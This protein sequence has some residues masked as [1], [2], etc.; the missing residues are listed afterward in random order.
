MLALF[1]LT[2]TKI[3]ASAS[4]KKIAAAQNTA[5]EG[6]F[7][8]E[9]TAVAYDD[10]KGTFTVKIKGRK[11]GKVFDKTLNISG[12]THPYAKQIWQ[13]VKTDGKGKVKLDVAIENNLS[14]DKF[15][16]KTNAGD[17][18]SIKNFFVDAL[19][20][21]LH[22]TS[23]S[24]VSITLGETD[25]YILKAQFEKQGDKIKITPEYIVKYNIKNTDGSETVEQDKS[26]S[27]FIRVKDDLIQNYFNAN[28]VFQY[29]LDKTDGNFIKVNP[30]E[31]A[32]SF[33]ARTKFLSGVPA[34]LFDETQIDSYIEKYKTKEADEHL[35]LDIMVGIYNPKNSGIKANDTEGSLTVQYCIASTEQLDGTPD[36]PA[37]TAIS[38]EITKQGFKKADKNTLKDLL[39]FKILKQGTGT[40]EEAKKAWKKYNISG[41]PAGT[42]MVFSAE[43]GVY[44]E[45][46]PFP[47]SM[48]AKPF[49][50]FINDYDIPSS[51]FKV[52]T[53]PHL[54]EGLN[55][56]KI[57]LNGVVLT[58]KYGD[59]LLTVTF[60]LSNN[61]T[62]DVKYTPT[63]H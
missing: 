41:K 12:F 3:T 13:I 43:N 52:D 21:S 32:S 5:V 56:V 29:I 54:S 60:T 47:A 51:V 55:G 14:I 22:T 16:E 31:F 50:I 8:E 11:D 37:I 49:K 20:F 23:S 38:K 39:V 44:S 63:F 7:F 25:E 10:E 57:L 61:D 15:I 33:Y 35:Q 28:D 45:V 9:A 4:A 36:A 62:V 59:E 19:T 46:L 34:D 48:N 17:G 26:Y 53:P 42:Y 58:K 6:F 18:A 30:N 1:N 27:S 2:E 40:D 24:S